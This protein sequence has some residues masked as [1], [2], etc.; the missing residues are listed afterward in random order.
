MPPRPE[1]SHACSTREAFK[2][3]LIV[4]TALSIVTATWILVANRVPALEDFAL[5]RNLTAGAI[6]CLVLLVPVIRFRKYPLQLFG[7]TIT[8][9]ALLTFLYAILQIPFPRLG[10]RM[11]TFHFFIMGAVVLGFAAAAAW[12][13]RLIVVLRTPAVAVRKRLS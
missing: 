2:S 9:W 4:G 8:S 11:G 10:A 12:V 13:I 6:T 3:G 7:C 1:L 5:W